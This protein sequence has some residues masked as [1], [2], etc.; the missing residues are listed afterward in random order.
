MQISQGAHDIEYHSECDRGDKGRHKLDKKQV[1]VV[2]CHLRH[3]SDTEHS[4]GKHIT[5]AYHQGLYYR[6]EYL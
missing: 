6:L 1:V 2:P 5:K 3:K 4:E